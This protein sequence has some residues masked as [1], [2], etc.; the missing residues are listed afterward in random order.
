MCS[1]QL[2]IF[3][4]NALL[5]FEIRI[6]AYHILTH[7]YD[8]N[9]FPNRIIPLRNSYTFLMQTKSLTECTYNHVPYII[10]PLVETY[11][12]YVLYIFLPCIIP[13]VKPIKAVLNPSYSSRHFVDFLQLNLFSSVSL[14]LLTFIKS[15]ETS[16]K[17]SV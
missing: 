9:H 3:S 4:Y 10:F 12:I 8:T 14:T 6:L 2:L 5:L 1:N 11:F 7:L 15:P 13:L 16:P 17:H